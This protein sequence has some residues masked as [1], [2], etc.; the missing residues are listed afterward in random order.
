M[1]EL[2]E[3]R[4][5]PFWWI[6]GDN[7]SV[8]GSNR[9]TGDPVRHLTSGRER[10]IGTTLIGAKC[11]SALQN[12]NGLF[13]PGHGVCY[14][15][16]LQKTNFLSANFSFWTAPAICG[17]ACIVADALISDS[18]TAAISVTACFEQEP[19]T[20]LGFVDVDF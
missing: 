8:Y 19:C 18:V 1:P 11:S 9:N 15:V 17:L 12:K 7:C 2:P 4:D 5:A 20:A 16:R 6:A 10:L 13:T 3:P 14:A